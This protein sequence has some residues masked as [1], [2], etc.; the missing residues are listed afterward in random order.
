MMPLT[1]LNSARNDLATLLPRIALRSEIA[2]EH[3]VADTKDA[4]FSVVKTI[5]RDDELARVALIETYRCVWREAAKV[6][7]RYTDPRKWLISVARRT[8]LTI[9]SVNAATS[10][11]QG[12]PIDS[13]TE[14]PI[15]L[16]ADYLRLH[17]RMEQ[18]SKGQ[19][20]AL[21][22][23]YLYG[24]SYAQLARATGHCAKS[25]RVWI[26]EGLSSVRET[27]RRG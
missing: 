9:A 26:R 8:A 15:V 20:A 10:S 7:L 14:L 12:L 6:D 18:M 11:R 3:L 24:V 13:P 19:G 27:K 1:K 5:I 16:T 23:S 4:L 22:L 17:K 21:R 2:F 25:V